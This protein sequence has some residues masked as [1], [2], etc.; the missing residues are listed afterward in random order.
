VDEVTA[1]MV[2][3]GIERSEVVI[4]SVLAKDLA[5]GFE[6]RFF[7]STLRMTAREDNLKRIIPAQKKGRLQC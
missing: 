2:S 3:Y 4:L 5:C 1:Y 6:A 7:A